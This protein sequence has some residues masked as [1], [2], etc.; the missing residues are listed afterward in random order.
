MQC[1][2]CQEFAFVERE[3]ADVRVGYQLDAVVVDPSNGNQSIPAFRLALQ[4]AFEQSDNGDVGH[5]RICCLSGFQE[6]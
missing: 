2:D 5:S 3:S 6:V 1:R 4:N